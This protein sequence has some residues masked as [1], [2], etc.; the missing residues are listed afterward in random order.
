MQ[1]QQRVG[2]GSLCG[3]LGCKVLGLRE[4]MGCCVARQDS[5]KSRAVARGH[6]RQSTDAQEPGYG[7]RH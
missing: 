2:E 1:Q 5:S 6:A 4:G 3:V 7:I